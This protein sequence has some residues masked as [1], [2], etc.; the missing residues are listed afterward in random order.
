MLE[1]LLNYIHANFDEAALITKNDRYLALPIL[2]QE[3][4]RFYELSLLDKRYIL[5]EP[6][7]EFNNIESLK[8][9]IM[10]IQSSMQGSVLLYLRQV[11][12]YRIKGLIQEQ[13]SFTNGQ[14]I[15]Y[16]YPDVLLNKLNHDRKAN[17][18]MSS[19]AQSII[20]YFLLEPLSKM[21]VQEVA[22]LIKLSEMSASR[23]LKELY[24][25]G[26][27]DYTISG[28]TKR[29]KAYYLNKAPDTFQRILA[30]S[31]SPIKRVVYIKDLPITQII[32]GYTAFCI[33]TRMQEDGIKRFAM[34][35][36]DFEKI[37]M[38]Y[39]E[40]AFNL[41]K[42]EYHELELWAYEPAIHGNT[43]IDDF[44]LFCLFKDD[45]DVRIEIEL[46][47]LAR[48]HG[49]LMDSIDL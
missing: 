39:Q 48:R 33:Q 38:I 8:K 41:R 49:W 25:H 21:N 2:Y 37:N 7:L 9:Q 46:D 5:V 30:Y 29:I 27:L 12:N 26:F 40:D 17:S 13:I 31:K 18:T 45:K 14:S 24:Q 16:I 43:I 34:H 15:L 32:S 44:S 10:M 20:R 11:N 28:K 35:I 3:S 23:G 19:T 1:Q 4:Y 42:H 6:N 47:E 36:R 22:K